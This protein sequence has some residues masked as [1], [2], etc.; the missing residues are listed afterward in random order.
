MLLLVWGKG[1]VDVCKQ[2]GGAG[3]CGVAGCGGGVEGGEL[4]YAC[5]AHNKYACKECVPRAARL[6][7]RMWVHC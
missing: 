5:T 4:V 2:C 1:G 6:D 7:V 3:T